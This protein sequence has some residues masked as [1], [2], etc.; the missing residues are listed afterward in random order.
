MATPVD[1]GVVVAAVYDV[2]ADAGLALLRADA[3]GDGA[4]CLRYARLPHRD[5][6]HGPCRRRTVHYRESVLLSNAVFSR[7]N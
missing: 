6:Q 5:H 3:A 7:T 2:H 1:G 4:K